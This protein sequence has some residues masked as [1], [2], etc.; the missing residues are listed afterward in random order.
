MSIR[1]FG[2]FNLDC[3]VACNGEKRI[4]FKLI[5]HLDRLSCIGAGI[6]CP[7]RSQTIS[8]AND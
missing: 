5:I 2:A 1:I 8:Q 7:S 4:D 6:A 3:G